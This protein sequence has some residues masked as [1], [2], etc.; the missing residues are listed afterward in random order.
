M[1]FKLYNL[2]VI[3]L[4]PLILLIRKIM[5]RR[6]IIPLLYHWMASGIRSPIRRQV[7]FSTI[8]S[9][10][11]SRPFERDGDWTKISVLPKFA[12][13]KKNW[14][15]WFGQMLAQIWWTSFQ[16]TSRSSSWNYDPSFMTHKLHLLRIIIM[17][18][19][20]TFLWHWNIHD[21]HDL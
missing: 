3:E 7:N 4:N 13:V 20:V 10:S 16:F 2:N 9:M 11:N 5:M 17:I 18:F 12:A 1:W 15:I 19:R 6:M 21:L 14:N 8:L